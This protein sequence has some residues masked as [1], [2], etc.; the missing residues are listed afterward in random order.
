MKMRLL[1]IDDQ[2]TTRNIV[3]DIRVDWSAASS[4]RADFF[5]E[6]DGGMLFLDEVADED[7]Y[8]RTSQF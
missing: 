7:L 3:S 8:Y 5:E 4:S 6:C 1:V 2:K